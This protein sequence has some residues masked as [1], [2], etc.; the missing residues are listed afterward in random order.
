[1]SLKAKTHINDIGKVWVI[2]PHAVR[3]QFDMLIFV[4][5]MTSTPPLYHAY[6]H[7]NWLLNPCLILSGPYHAYSPTAPSRYASTA[8]HP[9]ASAPLLMLSP[10]RLPSL[11][12][13]SA[14]KILL[15]RCHPSLFLHTT[16]SY[17]PY[18]S[19]VPSTY[20]SDTTTPPYASTPWPLTM[21]MLPYQIYRVWWLFGLHDEPNHRNM[22]SGFL[23]QHLLG[24]I[25]GDIHNVVV[26]A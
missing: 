3:Q 11:C 7:M 8:T 18:A 22:L 24:E 26:M 16:A 25:G 13:C 20:A 4:H 19:T 12:S 15:Q 14:L 2:T 21:L 17:H 23:Y 6:S 9:Y 5:E 1:M 10:L